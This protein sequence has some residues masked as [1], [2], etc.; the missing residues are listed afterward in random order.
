MKQI[1]LIALVALIFTSANVYADMHETDSDIMKADANNDGRVSFDEYKAAH[2]ERMLTR[3]KRRDV[4]G[5]GF[6]DLA[7]K[8]VAKEKSRLSTRKIKRLNN[9]HY[10]KSIKMIEKSVK[11]IF[12]SIS[13]NVIMFDAAIYQ[14]LT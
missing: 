10:V 8:Q 9:K 14:G 6:I 1:T 3:F 13:T 7:E 12:I 4:N 5:D 11:N 2:E